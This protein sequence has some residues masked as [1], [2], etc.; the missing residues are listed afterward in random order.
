MKKPYLI[1]VTLLLVFLS[2]CSS[3]IESNLTIPDDFPM[4]STSMKLTLSEAK[5]IAVDSYQEFFK[6]DVARSQSSQNLSVDECYCVTSNFDADTLMYVI[7]F[8]DSMGFALI[9]PDRCE[10][11]LAVV[12]K[13]FYNP[14]QET[15]NSDFDF[16]MQQLKEICRERSSQNNIALSRAPIS[17][18]IGDVVSEVIAGPYCEVSWGQSGIY[19]TYCP[20]GIAGCNNTTLAQIFSIFEYPQVLDLTFNNSERLALNWSDIKQHQNGSSCELHS[21]EI[22]NNIAKIMRELGY[23]SGSI[24][25]QDG[26]GTYPSN[27]AYLLQQL[28]FNVKL[29]EYSDD[30]VNQTIPL[31]K[32]GYLGVDIIVGYDPAQGGHMWMI[33]GYKDITKRYKNDLLN[34]GF[35]TGLDA[36]ITYKTFHY[37]HFNWGWNGNYNGYFIS[38]D[39]KG[40]FYDF[41]QNVTLYSVSL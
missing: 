31:N 17:S 37:N 28:G 7:N 18:G 32:T 30:F 14:S 5:A 34:P 6:N 40:A 13:G 15:G 38:G 3:D 22:H 4:E 21:N 39:Y 26:T 8:A 10:E 9:S 35:D 41:N 36:E 24:Y 11:P 29:S 12:E 23:R 2:S 27:S 1:I 25:E 20:N 19:G 16:Y 33:D